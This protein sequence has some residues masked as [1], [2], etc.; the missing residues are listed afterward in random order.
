MTLGY[1]DEYNWPSGQAAGRV[2]EQHPELAA[3][4]LDWKRYEVQ[5]NSTVQYDSL[6][7]A[8]A[9]K[10]VDNNIDASS[11]RIIGEGS[12]AKLESARGNW[13]VYT[14]SKEH[15]MQDSTT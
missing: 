11:L 2:L 5:G 12:S 3:R 13:V 15:I 4:Y 9:G 10:I 6:D 1:C 7:F 14:Y 8:V